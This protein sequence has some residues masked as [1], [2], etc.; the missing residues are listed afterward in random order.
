MFR[1]THTHAQEQ[2]RSQCYTQ[3]QIHTRTHKQTNNHAHM[4]FMHDVTHKPANSQTHKR[5]NTY[6]HTHTC[7]GTDTPGHEQRKGLDQILGSS[8]PGKIWSNPLC[9]NFQSVSKNKR[10]MTKV[11]ITA[12]RQNLVQSSACVFTSPYP[13]VPSHEQR[14]GRDQILGSSLPGQNCSNP[15]CCHFPSVTARQQTT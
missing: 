10:D 9:C 6:T 7:T 8:L 5:I 14:R 13:L 3:I 15:L 2:T 1:Q 12:R 4:H 11:P